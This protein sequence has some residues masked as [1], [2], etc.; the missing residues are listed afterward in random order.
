MGSPDNVA[1]FALGALLDGDRDASQVCAQVDA[2]FH[3]AVVARLSEIGA[4]ADK[5]EALAKL[6]RDVRPEP[7]SFEALPAAAQVAFQRT[8]TKRHRG[9]SR[10][11]PAIDADLTAALKR[12]AARL[13]TRVTP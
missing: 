11:G 8:L 13:H 5:R 12:L 4:S 9:A 3:S 6:V 7:T 10:P 1:G 2:V